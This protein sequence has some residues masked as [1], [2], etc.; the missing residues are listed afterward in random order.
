MP[1]ITTVLLLLCLFAAFVR[2][3]VITDVKKAQWQADEL[4]V[5]RGHD[6]LAVINTPEKWSFAKVLLDHANLP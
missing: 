1:T 5:D 4:C 3:A 2:Y 6:G